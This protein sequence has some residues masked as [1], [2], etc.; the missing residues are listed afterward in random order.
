VQASLS[1]TL[2]TLFSYPE[3]YGEVRREIFLNVFLLASTC[4]KNVMD[5]Q[6]MLDGIRVEAENTG[7]ILITVISSMAREEKRSEYK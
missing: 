5:L 4:D 2:E 7:S 6:I 3:T 1:C